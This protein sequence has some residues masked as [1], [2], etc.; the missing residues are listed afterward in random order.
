[1]SLL[2]G[3]LFLFGVIHINPAVPAWKAHAVQTFGR[4]YGAIYGILSLF[5]LAGV[6]WAFQKTEPVT[7]YDVPDWGRTANFALSL[8]GFAFIGIFLFRGSWRN[9]IKYPMA[10]GVC[11]WALGHLFANGDQRT[12]L[13]FVG[14]AGFAVLHAV[15]KSRTPHLPSEERSGHNLLSV[16][17][18]VALYGLAAQLHTVIAGVPVIV[19]H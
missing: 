1:M 8:V 2:L 9:K 17:G 3:F 15:L 7:L 14:L 12:A 19:L 5:L 18:G 6:M 11:L 16:L 10:I 4:G 13:L